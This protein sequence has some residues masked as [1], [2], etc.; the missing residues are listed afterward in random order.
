MAGTISN[1][2]TLIHL[3]AI[4]HINLLCRFYDEILVPPAVWEEVVEKGQGRAGAKE[5]EKA[6]D[7]GWLKVKGAKN[8]ELIRSLKRELDKGEAETIALALEQKADIIL[9]DE[10]Y[11]RK[12]ADEYDLP[13][14]GVIGILIRAKIKGKISSLRTELERLRQDVGFWISEDLYEQALKA[15]GEAD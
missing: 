4:G 1:S 10:S 7:A 3:A 8:K 15:V 9:L 11:A 13:K 12:I 14:T 5:V 6:A 2:S